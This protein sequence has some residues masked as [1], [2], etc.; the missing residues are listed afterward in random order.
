MKKIVAILISAVL[1]LS[2]FPALGSVQA[3]TLQTIYDVD[4]ENGTVGEKPPTGS[5]NWTI[6]SIAENVELGNF[7][8]IGEETPGGNK[9]LKLYRSAD[10][11]AGAGIRGRCS[12]NL[13]GYKTLVLRF[14]FKGNGGAT[15]AIVMNTTEGNR[16]LCSITAQEWTNVEINFDLENCRATSVV[17]DAEPTTVTLRSDCAS[18]SASMRFIANALQPGT[19][20]A[21]YDDI[22]IGTYDEDVYIR[23]SP[24][25]GKQ[26]VYWQYVIPK[27]PM[28]EDSYV[29][30]LKQSHPRVLVRDWDEIRDKVDDNVQSQNWYAN[31][32]SR[33][34]EALSTTPQKYVDDNGHLKLYAAR[35]AQARMQALAFVYNIEQDEKYL[36]KAYEEMCYYGTYKN[37]SSFGQSL[38]CA[39]IVNGFACAY[40]WL[41]NDLTD[42]QKQ[43]LIAI[44]KDKGLS[45]F[46]YNYEN[47]YDWSFAK[48]SI[49]WNPVCNA[50]V[51]MAAIAIADEVPE[52]SEYFLEMAL[53]SLKLALAPYAPQGA[54][55]EGVSYW[56]YGTTFLVFACDMLE[57][58]FNED[59]VIPE[60][61]KYFEAE[62]M[63]D[64]CDFAIYMNGPTGRFDYGD[65]V[66]G[67]T[68]C[69]VLYWAAEKYN[70]P[71]YAWWENEMQAK[72]GYLTGYSAIASL[73]WYNPANAEGEISDFSLD[74]F[75]DAETSKFNGFSARSSWDEE[76]AMFT[77]MQGGINKGSHLHQTLGT[78][79]VDYNGKRFIRQA[80]GANYDLA[81]EEASNVIYGHRAEAGNCLVINPTV[82]Y[83]QKYGAFAALTDYESNAKSAYGILDMNDVYST[84]KDAEGAPVVTSAKRGL[85]LTHERSRVVVQDEVTLASPSE[86][87]WFAATDAAV[88]IAEDGRSAVL[89]LGGEKM[90]AR[91]LSAPA[92]AKLE[93]MDRKSVVAE[94]VINNATSGQK[95]ALHMENQVGDVT[96]AVEYVPLTDEV[97]VPGASAV[98]PL[99]NWAAQ[100]GQTTQTATSYIEEGD[101]LKFTTNFSGE[102]KNG[103]YLVLTLYKDG[104][105]VSTKLTPYTGGGSVTSVLP[106][107]EFDTVKIV[108]MESFFSMRILSAPETILK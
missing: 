69:E 84:V 33:A 87:W 43:N 72:H 44:L 104:A 94:G 14:R 70:K 73:I 103:G 36:N 50:S 62:G 88:T 58:S 63:E 18:E 52:M 27:N 31:I 85:K 60:E 95:L 74:K 39:E 35:N 20:S 91:I 65:C 98:L 55:P 92:E 81:N 86:L 2:L 71:H 56:D 15:G 13:K 25:A 16:T 108:F 83:D 45:G 67:Y 66:S 21:Y 106:K 42:A 11:T 28:G 61:F 41:Y 19:N 101:A 89:D 48:I 99:A 38:V 96:I 37:W 102:A 59:F 6:S 49:N 7:V 90:L 30:Q 57:H 10:S 97:S 47:M 82:N 17:G 12:L 5:T 34:D 8:R 54:Y 1:L 76:T 107:T 79:V 75:Y 78:Y 46:V 3:E 53:P 68:S 40:D 23:Q 100:S 64:T 4:F 51:M 32:K 26:G 80:D 77:A 93:M 29:S 9:V 22:F 24:V 105:P